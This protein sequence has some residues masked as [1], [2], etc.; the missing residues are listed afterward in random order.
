VSYFGLDYAEAIHYRDIIEARITKH[1]AHRL[2][3][4]INAHLPATDCRFTLAHKLYHYKFEHS[5]SEREIRVRIFTLE[6]FQQML[7]RER[8]S[9][10]MA[11]MFALEL[12]VP[13]SLLQKYF[14][15]GC[16]FQEVSD[17]F[18]VSKEVASRAVLSYTHSL[19]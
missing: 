6:E 13:T 9:E 14:N 8:R 17:E 2:T 11:E 19:P 1:R 10:E 16:G 3:A 4:V 15:A 12:L 18:H 5:L 7:P